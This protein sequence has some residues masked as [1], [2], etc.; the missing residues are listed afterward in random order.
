MRLILFIRTINLQV[1]KVKHHRHNIQSFFLEFSSV[2][3]NQKC[4]NTIYQ[5]SSLLWENLVQEISLSLMEYDEAM[6]TTKR[7]YCFILF[8]CYYEQCIWRHQNIHVHLPSRV[9]F[10]P[11]YFIH[12]KE[13]NITFLIEKQQS[14][15][16]YPLINA[17]THSQADMHMCS[18]AS[19][20]HICGHNFV[21][22]DISTRDHNKCKCSTESTVDL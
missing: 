21:H 11:E 17:N 12:G 3:Q 22:A 18:N 5:T 20:V 2:S 8:W 19:L 10:R 16:F 15:T 14:L 7:E 6:L 13:S 4:N 9:L 1:T